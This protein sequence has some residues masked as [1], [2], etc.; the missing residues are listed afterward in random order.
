MKE[1]ALLFPGQ[2]SQFVGMGKELCRDYPIAEETFQEANQ[3]LGFDLQQLCFSGDLDELT[4]TEN[5]Q[6]AILTASIAAFRVYMDEIG[7]AP[8]F[9]AGH[10]LGEY[11]ALVA[12]GALKFE[13]AL[14]IVRKRGQYMQEAVP[15]GLGTMMAVMKLDY[16]LIEEVCQ[17]VSNSEEMVVPANIN[18]KQQI[19]ISGHTEAVKRAGQQLEEEGGYVKMLN[20]SAPFHS[21]LMQPAADK[22]A[23]ELEKYTLNQ[24]KWPV[25]SNVTALPYQTT[26][27]LRKKLTQQIVEPVRWYESMT[28]LNK[29]NVNTAVEMGPK[30]VLKSLMRKSYPDIKVVKFDNKEDLESIRDEMPK[31]DLNK[32]ISKSLAVLVC[33]QNHNPDQNQYQEGVVKPYKQIES[34]RDKIETEDREATVEEAKEA[35]Q[36]L[37]TALENKLVPKEELQARFQEIIA[38][39]GTANI[40]E[41]YKAV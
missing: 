21:P 36:L 16:P 14:K 39:S 38:L 31:M 17:E 5:A 35:L 9:T 7:L 12:A 27:K 33:T 2:G 24:M 29:M 8:H 20:V 22:M 3:V 19:V 18:S 34:L 6:P 28:Y 23:K 40:F 26:D 13:D 32:V 11:S 15:V 37:K 4:R 1:L 10:S 25:I 41:E 30:T